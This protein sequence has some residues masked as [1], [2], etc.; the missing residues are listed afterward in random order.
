MKKLL[1]CAATLVAALGIAYFG[2]T[3]ALS[4]TAALAG[5][6]PT[7]TAVVKIEV[8]KGHGSGVHLGNG[9][10]LT[11]A[12][13]VSGQEEVVVKLDDG[14][15]VVA[16]DVLWQNPKYDVALLRVVHSD[17]VDT[18]NLECRTVP[19]G[20]AIQVRGNPG[21]IEFVDMRGYAAGE[22]R[23]FGPWSD[24]VPTDITI[25]GGVSG[26]GVFD[27]DGDLVGLAVGGLLSRVGMSVSVTGVTFIVP[28]SAVCELLARS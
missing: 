24:V 12:H 21:K 5:S 3:T 7:H 25:V 26:G 15:S 6:A 1:A 9:Y 8:D 20:E 28:G 18:A 13:V 27:A 14:Q 22:P 2:T 16:A 4:G 23:A 17:G 11:A 19:P 10:V